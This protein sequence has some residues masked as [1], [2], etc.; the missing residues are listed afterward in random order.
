M[1][2]RLFDLLCIFILAAPVIF[3]AVCCGLL[4]LFLNGRPVL[5]WSKRVG[6]NGSVF[7]MPKFRTMVKG[8]PLIETNGLEVSE[9]AALVTPL[10]KYLRLFGLDEIPQFWSVL[11]GDMSIVGPRPAILSQQYL[12]KKRL[13]YG[14]SRLKPG[15][16]GYAQITGRDSLNNNEKLACDVIYLR[17]CSFGFDM[18]ILYKTV[19]VVLAGRGVRH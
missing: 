16:T 12:N 17:K 10:G 6:Q 4:V 7:C 19:Q 2:K 14:V 18:Y 13:R 3:I 5:Y 8:A 11:K 15:I 1:Y 9:A